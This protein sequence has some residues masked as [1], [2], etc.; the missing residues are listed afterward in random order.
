MHDESDLTAAVA[1]EARK[2][3]PEERTAYLDGV[4]AARPELRDGVERLLKETGRTARA[5]EVATAQFTPA[6]GQP[7][8]DPYDATMMPPDTTIE[9]GSSVGPYKLLQELGAGGMGVVYEATDPRLD[10]RVA[11][12]VLPPDLTQDETAK[13]RF[14]HVRTDGKSL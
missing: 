2:R 4:C 5:D 10:R 6:E 9:E 14:L 1:E 11:I 3:S 8:P 7:A 12:K 13:Q